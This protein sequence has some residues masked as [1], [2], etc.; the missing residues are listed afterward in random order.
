[1]QPV[2]VEMVRWPLD[3]IPGDWPAWRDRWEYG[4]VVRAGFVTFAL[5]ALT[6]SLLTTNDGNGSRQP[7]DRGPAGF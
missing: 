5:A 2:N 6:W 1:M 3:A 4:H 7:V